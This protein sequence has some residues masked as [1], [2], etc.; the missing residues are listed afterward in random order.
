MIVG[1]GPITEDLKKQAEDLGIADRVIFAGEV[2]HD[3][4]AI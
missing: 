2:P 3:K 4:V 1:R